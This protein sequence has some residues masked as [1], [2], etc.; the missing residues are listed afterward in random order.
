M[1]HSLAILS[2]HGLLIGIALVT[3]G[4]GLFVRRLAELV[5]PLRL[6]LAERGEK[7]LAVSKDGKEQ[8]SVKFYL[9][10]A[11]N[12]WISIWASIL[13]P[14]LAAY[15]SIWPSSPK[16]VA[17]DEREYRRISALFTIS[18]LSA[19]PLF[20]LIIIIELA[21]GTILIVIFSGNINVLF[22]VALTLIERQANKH[23]HQSHVHAH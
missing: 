15:Q 5:Q 18:V 1:Q 10:N 17:T 2:F 4:Y 7:Y 22:R 6:Q 20:G 16:F 21:D 3:L 8:S 14:M 9:D 23:D 13:L 19:N 12:P 11:L